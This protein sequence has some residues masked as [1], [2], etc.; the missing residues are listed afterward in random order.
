[1]FLLD[2]VNNLSC[3]VQ[4]WEAAGD[5]LGI[6]TTK[7]EDDSF[8]SSVLR[9]CGFDTHGWAPDPALS[10]DENLI[11]LVLI[12]TRSSRLRQGGM[13]CVLIRPPASSPDKNDDDVGDDEPLSP[14]AGRQQQHPVADCETTTSPTSAWFDGRIISLATNQPLYREGHSD[15]HAEVAAL[16]RAA[17]FGRATDGAT[18]YITMPPCKR[19]FGALI[20]A[21]IRRIVTRHRIL[22]AQTSSNKGGDDIVSAVQELGIQCAVVPESEEQYRRIRDVIVVAG[23][24]EE[25]ASGVNGE[26]GV[27]DVEFLH[28]GVF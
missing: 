25:D 13:A 14:D 3:V 21:G 28:G 19:C 12:V 4:P 22:P 10:E 5:A 9:S 15:I 20:A 26:G 18:A 8:R 23:N 2:C 11:D 16:G 6:M 24:R 1:V 27:D 17:R 7:D